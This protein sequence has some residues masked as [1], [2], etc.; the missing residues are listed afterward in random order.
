MANT[1][2]RRGLL[3]WV[4]LL[5]AGCGGGGDSPPQPPPKATGWVST[6]NLPFAVNQVELTL[7]DS[8]KV[9]ATGGIDGPSDAAVTSAYLF[10]S[11]PGTW[12]ATAPLLD[13]RGTHRSVKLP[14]GKVLALG[15][16]GAGIL[17]NASAELYDPTSGTWTHTGAMSAARAGPAAAFLK[18]G[19]LL[20]CGGVASESAMPTSSAELYDPASGTFTATGDLA[21]A[22]WYATATPLAS[23]QVLVV[24]GLTGTLGTWGGTATA[25]VYNPVAG[26]WT[27]AGSLPQVS[28]E[29]TAT[30]LKDGRVLV[31]GGATGGWP[32]VPSRR[33]FL[34]D[35]VSGWSETGS[36][37]VARVG[38]V[39][40]LLSSGG[41]MVAAG[42][43]FSDHTSTT[44]VYD[45]VSGT[46]TY[47]DTMVAFHGHLPGEAVLANGDWLV[48]GGLNLVSAGAVTLNAS[49]RWLLP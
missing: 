17:S 49:E 28:Y 31:A 8:G 46:W 7:L 32:L 36:L 3:M 42:T 6:Q 41:V 16:W 15:G 2:N 39:A 9:L 44:E 40:R 29:H 10:D 13:P 19:K 25:E 47:A 26:T 5:L 35:P 14:S 33:A 27:S 22:R 12:T 11:V 20:V 38:H 1:A 21:T 24:G 34:Y 37:K 4:S 43:L 30:L 18:S 45:P 23:G 48:A